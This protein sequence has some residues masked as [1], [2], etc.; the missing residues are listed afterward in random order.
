MIKDIPYVQP[1]YIREP[2]KHP[3]KLLG[4]FNMIIQ[5][6]VYNVWARFFVCKSLA[7]LMI[8]TACFCNKFVR[9]IRTA[10]K[11]IELEDGTMVSFL[12]CGPQIR[13]HA[14]EQNVVSPSIYS[15]SDCTLSF[16]FGLRLQPTSQQKSRLELVLTGSSTN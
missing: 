8:M 9:A 15:K 14:Q 4:S 7:A 13:K 5:L 10:G 3:L 1:S 16:Q 6:A 2:I 11:V 12:R